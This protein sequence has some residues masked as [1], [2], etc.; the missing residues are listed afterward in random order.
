MDLKGV[1]KEEILYELLTPV[2]M[3]LSSSLQEE[4]YSALLK[5]EKEGSTGI[6]GG[7]A[8]PH[9][10][11]KGFPSLRMGVGIHRKGVDFSALDGK[12]VFLFILLLAPESETHLYLALLGRIA[13][14]FRDPLH[15]ERI[16]KMDTREGVYEELSTSGLLFT[17]V[18]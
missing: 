9:G 13:T 6:G 8:L 18:V 10:R 3:D 12:P 15:M 14:Y 16:L 17:Q 5:R 7:I 11:V 1:G 2:V 4:C